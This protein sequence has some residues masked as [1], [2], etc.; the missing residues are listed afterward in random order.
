MLANTIKPE[1]PATTDA[2]ASERGSIEHSALSSRSGLGSATMADIQGLN[3]SVSNKDQA[4]GYLPQ[5]QLLLGE[6]AKNSGTDD[7]RSSAAAHR[8]FAVGAHGA[9]KDNNLGDN[10]TARTE[11][12]A[13]T[14]AE[15]DKP[16]EAGNGKIE[17]TGGKLYE[18]HGLNHRTGDHNTP[19]AM[20]LLPK[21]FDPSKPIHL[22]VDPVRG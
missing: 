6:Y 22:M 17:P 16:L 12:K 7:G 20:V 5:L 11:T 13:Q 3:N 14:K 10:G 21:N 4:G 15:T 1:Q 19:D 2:K 8:G 18:L 9:D